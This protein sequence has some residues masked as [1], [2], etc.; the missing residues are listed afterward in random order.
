MDSNL[1]RDID[2]YMSRQKRETYSQVIPTVPASTNMSIFRVSVSLRCPQRHPEFHS[3]PKTLKGSDLWCWLERTLCFFVRCGF[4]R[5]K[6]DGETSG[7]K[8]VCHALMERWGRLLRD[9][10]VDLCPSLSLSPKARRAGTDQTV[11]APILFN[12]LQPMSQNFKSSLFLM[13]NQEIGRRIYTPPV[14]LDKKR[15]K[16]L[17]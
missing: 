2:Y 13:R 11:P 16:T 17:I 14:Y 1:L 5:P 4:G 7:E 10:L 8:L 3:E 15:R 9:P 6:M 12:C